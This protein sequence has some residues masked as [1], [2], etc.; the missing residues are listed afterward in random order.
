MLNAWLECVWYQQVINMSVTCIC[1]FLYAP[2]CMWPNI[3][4]SLGITLVDL[5]VI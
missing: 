5:D 3:V 1:M 4:I 2:L